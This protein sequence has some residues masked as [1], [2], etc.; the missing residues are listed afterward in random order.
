MGII[1]F[2]TVMGTIRNALATMNT[3]N[4][5]SAAREVYRINWAGFGT[6]PAVVTQFLFEN[7]ASSFTLGVGPGWACRDTGSRVT[8]Q[9]VSGFKTGGDAAT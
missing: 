8:G 5:F 7:Y 2:E 6:C 9:A 3:D 1:I 4:W